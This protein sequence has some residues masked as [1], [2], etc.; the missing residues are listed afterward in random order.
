QYA[1]GT[2]T[3]NLGAAPENNFSV[4]NGNG[5]QV[6]ITSYDI[7]TT[8]ASAYGILAQSIG[9]GGGLIGLG[10]DLYA[11]STGTV[12]SG[13]TG[14]GGGIAIT[15]YGTL[16]AS[17]ENSIG[18]FAQSDGFSGAGLITIDVNGAVVGGSGAQGA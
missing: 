7:T 1:Q 3:L 2:A 5:G 13:L 11:G 18:I 15:Q 12:D 8:G 9:G 6:T 10:S 4:A 16:S 17:G 14:T